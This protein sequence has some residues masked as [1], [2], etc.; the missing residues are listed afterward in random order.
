MV[1]RTNLRLRKRDSSRRDTLL[2]SGSRPQLKATCITLARTCVDPIGQAA[3]HNE[4]V[5]AVQL[6][7]CA[8]K[9]AQYSISMIGLLL[10]TILLQ[11]CEETCRFPPF[12]LLFRKTLAPFLYLAVG[13]SLAKAST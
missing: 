8:H 7:S 2:S 13:T 12:S 1:K 11:G 3:S 5:G 9:H 4:I 10:V 6:P